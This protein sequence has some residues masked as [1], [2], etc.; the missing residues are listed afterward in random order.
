MMANAGGSCFTA[1]STVVLIPAFNEEDAIAAVIE[2]IGR[3]CDLPVVVIDDA[4][5]DETSVCARRAG[6]VVIPLCTNLGAW[7][8]TQAGLRYALRHGYDFAVT[9]DADGQHQASSLEALSRP[10]VEEKADVVIGACLSRGSKMRRIAWTVMKEISGL[11]LEDITS[12]FRVYNQRA[13]RTLSSWQGTLLD[14]QDI[15]VLLLLQSSG[16]RITDVEVTM[17]ERTNGHSRVFYSWSI[18]AYYMCHSLL[19]GLSKRKLL[20]T[21][22]K[23]IQR[24]IN[25]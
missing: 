7:G 17:R 22:S 11:S 4:S 3:A 23:R 20:P 5:T 14:Y 9:M 10:I 15:G 8:A 18:V 1:Q 21:G 25:L 12:G 13:I 16:F 19:L 6:A 24:E 2:E